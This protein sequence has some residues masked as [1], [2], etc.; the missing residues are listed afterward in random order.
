MFCVY[1]ALDR[2]S[3]LGPPSRAA[4]SGSRLSGIW[5]PIKPRRTNGTPRIGVA[6]R[7]GQRSS[8]LWLPQ[9]AAVSLRDPVSE[10]GSVL[11]RLGWSELASEA[12]DGDAHRVG[13]R[14]GVFVPRLLE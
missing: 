4:E 6:A 8:H 7:A 11:N 10:S 9:L 2:G 14:V 12:T 5:N 13:E 1:P 3:A